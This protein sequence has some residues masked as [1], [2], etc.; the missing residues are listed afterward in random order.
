[1]GRRGGLGTRRRGLRQVRL[2]FNPGLQR[3]TPTRHEADAGRPAGPLRAVAVH[4]AAGV[5]QAGGLLDGRLR[6]GG[7]HLRGNVGRLLEGAVPVGGLG[8][9]DVEEDRLGRGRDGLLEHGG[10]EELRR[11]G[12]SGPVLYPQRL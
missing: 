12:T 5:A 6:E 7:V 4:E 8:R 9:G 11:E 3:G 10:V 1:M 2:R